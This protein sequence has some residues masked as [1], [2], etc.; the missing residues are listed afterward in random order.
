MASFPRPNLITNLTA[1]ATMVANQ[2]K[3][4]VLGASG[5]A[6]ASTG[7]NAIGI[8]QNAPISGGVCEIAIV[9]GGG[10]AIA[11]ATIAAGNLLEVDSAGLL[12][13]ATGAAEN[14][15]AMALQSAVVNDVFAVQVLFDRNASVTV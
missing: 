15:V 14:I 3:A 5:I 1:S 4:V 7:Q 12:V 2:Y 8:L 11:G 13:H 9:G 10:L 6:L